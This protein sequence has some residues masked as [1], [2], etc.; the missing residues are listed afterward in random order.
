MLKKPFVMGGKQF[1]SNIFCAPLAGCSDL[2]FR[3]MTSMYKPGLIYCEMVKMDALIRHDPGTFRLLDYERGMHPI[4]AQLCGSKPK[5]AKRCAKICEDLGFDVVDLNCGC[6]VDKVTRDGSGSGLLKS[7]KLIGEILSE[8]L[9]G[10]KVPVTLKVRLGWDFENINCLEICRIAREAGASAVCI[11][12]RTRSQ[13]YNGPADWGPIAACKKEFPEL[14]IIGNGD[15]VDAEAAAKIFEE[16]KCDAILVARGSFGKPW[17]IEDIYRKLSG[18]EP[19]KR[20]GITY[21][22]HLLMHL[23][24]IKEYQPERK[25]VLD[26]RRVGCWYLKTAPNAKRLR[27]SL[28]Q[29]KTLAEV[30]DLIENYPWQEV[31]QEV[32][33]ECEVLYS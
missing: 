13:G 8:M 18:D 16:T 11:H 26:M 5:L 12:G 25:A 9:S 32:A 6:P 22:T 15:I 14:C 31:R 10:V 20:D 3:R 33:S 7:P 29:A 21:R 23:Q 4:G 30:E 28:N 27:E 19:L 1:P 24:N 17:V 2:P